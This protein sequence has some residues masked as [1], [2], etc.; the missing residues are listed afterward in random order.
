MNNRFQLFFLFFIFL[1]TIKLP[2]QISGEPLPFPV[3]EIPK[4][5]SIQ[6]ST[7]CSIDVADYPYFK[8]EELGDKTYF[9]VSTV[10][11]VRVN[12][13][14]YYLNSPIN[15]HGVKLLAKANKPILAIV[16]LY[17]ADQNYKPLSII[18]STLVNITSYGF[19]TANFAAPVA[20]NANFSIGIKNPT[21][22][23]LTMY[24][25]NAK[26]STYG[27]KLGWRRLPNLTWSTNESAFGQDLEWIVSP[28]ISYNLSTSFTIDKDTV[29]SG[30][31]V[32]TAN[33]STSD[34][35]ISK[36]RMLSYS[37]FGIH[38]L[39][40]PDSTFLWKVNGSS[41]SI[42]EEPS[43]SLSPFGTKVISLHGKVWGFY[44]ICSDVSSSLTAY[45]APLSSLSISANATSACA[46]S[47][48]S[49]S[50]IATGGIST[51]QYLWSDA[52]LQTTSTAI[53][54]PFGP[55]SVTVTDSLTGC[56]SSTS[57]FVNET[58]AAV[59]N[60]SFI[61]PTCYGLGN[62]SATLSSA[63]DISAYTFSWSNSQTGNTATGLYASTYSV[64]GTD[65][66]CKNIGSVSL[67]QPSKLVVTTSASD[68]ICYRDS[69]GI[70]NVVVTGGTSPYTYLWNNGDS[71]ALITNLDTGAYIV[72]V[73]DKNLCAMNDTAIINEPEILA[74]ELDTIIKEN[75][76]MS[77]G[78]IKISVMGGNSA[79]TY[80]W[81]PNIGNSDSV[82]NLAG[83]TYSVTVTDNKGCMDTAAFVVLI[84]AIEDF[85][86]PLHI[87]LSPNPVNHFLKLHSQIDFTNATLYIA[88]SKGK[89][90][91]S[92]TVSNNGSGI[93]A[94]IDTGNFASGM[95]FIKLEV[96]KKVFTRKFVKL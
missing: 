37:G 28:M 32:I 19:Y 3:K 52:G 8:E 66:T 92:N 18:D 20:Y 48:G 74:I 69:N 31:A 1:I 83:G 7:S 41:V 13:Q 14:G 86:N 93:I 35:D 81:L 96:D 89:I 75:K 54:L 44:T 77:D 56:K 85:E 62:G 73:K 45:S 71:T 21:T 50:V 10:G 55:Y 17:A 2:A 26:S 47:D 84:D 90:I 59:I 79:Y 76:D 64:N 95:Y 53:G 58:G 94:N 11:T 80:D 65:G 6:K 27:E 68:V 22:D 39:Q 38:W 23:T 67:T 24:T 36:N 5:N 72:T 88:D 78:I 43:I 34:Y 46:V 63:S 49:A 51:Y 82:F 4:Q 33:T 87:S 16:Y 42:L 57:T 25:N 70:A 61:S 91:Y 30:S 40:A 12:A 29:C 15:I 60:I 9:G